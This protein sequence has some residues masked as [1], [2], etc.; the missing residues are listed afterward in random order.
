MA[1]ASHVKQPRLK[2]QA[3]F[4]WTLAVCLRG[5][6]YVALRSESEREY[7]AL[8][9]PCTDSCRQGNE[10]S[11]RSVKG[12]KEVKRC[13]GGQ[14]RAIHASR[15]VGK[16]TSPFWAEVTACTE[17]RAGTSEK[18]LASSAVWPDFAGER[19]VAGAA[20]GH[21]VRACKDLTRPEFR[22]PPVGRGAG[23]ACITHSASF[24][25]TYCMPGLRRRW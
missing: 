7:P 5:A 3:H 1:P 23:R 12:S 25:S 13:R 2:R 17:A 24:H 15:R 21:G 10:R 14:W 8:V 22:L 11:Q 9:E 19:G 16:V 4:P 18:R 20:A 6:W